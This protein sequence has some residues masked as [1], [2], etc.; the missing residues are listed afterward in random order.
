MPGYS[1]LARDGGCDHGLN[2]GDPYAHDRY[3]CDA[4]NHDD[5]PADVYSDG[6][7]N[8][9]AHDGANAPSRSLPFLL[10]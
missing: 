3:A 2:D 4:P 6:H 5:S 8:V 7:A 1:W 10:A 9:R